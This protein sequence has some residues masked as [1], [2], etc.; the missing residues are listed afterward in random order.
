MGKELKSSVQ[1]V[2][3]EIINADCSMI[4]TNIFIELVEEAESE[5]EKQAYFT[6]YNFFL[7]ERQKRVMEGAG[8]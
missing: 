1:F 4:P 8:I 7:G 6:L 2:V 3:R 5:L